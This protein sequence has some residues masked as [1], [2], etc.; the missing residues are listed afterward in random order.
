MVLAVLLADYGE[1]ADALA[2]D[3][4]NN[5]RF[6]CLQCIVGFWVDAKYAVAVGSHRAT[7]ALVDAVDGH[8]YAGELDMLAALVSGGGEDEWFAF[9]EAAERIVGEAALAPDEGARLRLSFRAADPGY[10]G[11]MAPLR[12]WCLG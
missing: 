1:G 2:L 4:F 7:R 5:L 12:D 11:H 6:V 10:V 8:A 9:A 3:A